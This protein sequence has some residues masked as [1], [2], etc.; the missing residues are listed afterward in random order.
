MSGFHINDGLEDLDC[1]EREALQELEDDW[2]EIGRI[3][4]TCEE[5]DGP[6]K[7]GGIGMRMEK[8]DS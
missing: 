7:T 1:P 3:M 4:L 2:Q 6:R 8:I 5:T